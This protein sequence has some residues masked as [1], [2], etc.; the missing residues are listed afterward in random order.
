MKIA[1]ISSL[2]FRVP[3]VRYGGA[4]MSTHLLTEGLVKKGHEVI[5]FA[6]GDSL[7]EA[8]LISPYPIHFEKTHFDY[9]SEQSMVYLNIH[10]LI[11]ANNEGRFDVINFHLSLWSD[12]VY[13]LVAKQLNTKCVF[14]VRYTIPDK[15]K[16]P[17]EYQMLSNYKNLNFVSISK[18]QQRSNLKLNW[19]AN[20]YNSVDQKIYTYNGN[21]GDYFLW[22]GSIHPYKG[23]HLAI[24]A[25]KQT[26]SKLV[27]AGKINKSIPIAYDYWLK[28]IYPRIDGKQIIFKG[29]TT[30]KQTAHL[31]SHAVAF[32]NP[33]QYDEPFGLVM[34]E[35]MA[36]G[37]PVIVFDRGSAQEI[38]KN[39]KTGFIVKNC[40]EMMTAMKNV[41]SIKRYDCFKHVSDKFNINTMIDNYEKLYS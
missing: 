6:S 10:N 2:W 36:C 21:K 33:I 38:V 14:T 23:L 11:K 1:Q 39:K 41:T 37:V 24:G 4:E 9:A 25:A 5:L 20:I 18:S 16:L 35:S 17:L 8:K 32:L 22:V 3:P 13:F 26:K 19:I 34:V 31:M 28:E 12:Y 15:K 40:E 27:I 29:E 7:T 30:R